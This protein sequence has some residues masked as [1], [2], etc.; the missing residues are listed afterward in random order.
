MSQNWIP[1]M[2]PPWLP[3]VRYEIEWD[4]KKG[5]NKAGLTLGGFTMHHASPCCG[6]IPFING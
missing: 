1:T 4:A 3:Q 6:V 2:Y 5:K